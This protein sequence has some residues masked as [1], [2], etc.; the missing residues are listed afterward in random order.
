MLLG[1]QYR[2]TSA[3]HGSFRIE[4]LTADPRC[5]KVRPIRLCVSFTRS[6]GK[7]DA[8]KPFAAVRY[9]TAV[10]FL[11][12]L[13]YHGLA[14]VSSVLDPDSHG[15]A[16]SGSYFAGILVSRNSEQINI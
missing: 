12:Y 15:S 6:G 14:V 10:V 2:T 16:S 1:E 11:K 9:R 13:T 4:K 8:G 3:E 7:Y 5:I